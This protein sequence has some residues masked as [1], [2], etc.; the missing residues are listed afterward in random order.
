[1][2]PENIIFECITGSN[3]YGTNVEGSDEDRKGVCV[4]PPEHYYGFTSSFEQWHHPTEDIEIYEIKKFFKLLSNNNPNIIDL[5]F[6]PEKYWVQWDHLWYSLVYMN[7]YFF[8]SKKCKFTFMGYATAQLRRIDSHR[9]W[10]LN[11]PTK[12]PTREDFGFTKSPVRADLIRAVLSLPIE[13][14]ADNIREEVLK[15][16][17]Y[18]KALEGWNSYL[19]WKKHRNR[20][21]AVSEAKSGYDTKH[22]MH[23]IRLMRMGLEILTEGEVFVDRRTKDYKELLSIRNGEWEWE[24]VLN[25]VTEI[26]KTMDEA[27]LKTTL[28]DKPKTDLMENVCEEFIKRNLK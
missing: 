27:Y 14:L 22:A 11:P 15:E 7:R 5:V 4:A 28:Q 9:K 23:L 6:A 8:L 24:Q 12:Q 13:V 21:R 26:E 19:N 1:V 16:Q 18:Q 10:L 3:L 20:Q 17:K 2:K 25:H